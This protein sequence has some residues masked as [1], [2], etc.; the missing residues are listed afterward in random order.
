MRPVPNVNAT[1]PYPTSTP[2]KGPQQVSTARIA[3]NNFRPNVMN[4][5]PVVII[6]TNWGGDG[7]DAPD[8]GWRAFPDQL[9]GNSYGAATGVPGPFV[10]RWTPLPYG[11]P[12]PSGGSRSA[13]TQMRPAKAPLSTA[14]P[15]APVLGAPPGPSSIKTVP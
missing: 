14:G 9:N 12:V 6:P 2:W 15:R 8:G 5:G 4:V 3:A 7:T 1:P 13:P 10:P 11:P